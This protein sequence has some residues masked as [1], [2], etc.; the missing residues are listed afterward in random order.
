MPLFDDGSLGYLCLMTVSALLGLLFTSVLIGTITNAIEVKLEA[1]R[2]GNSLVIEKNHIV[3][4]GFY[5]GEYTLLMR[6][7]CRGYSSHG[8]GGV[9]R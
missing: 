9:Y 2:N 7:G 5:P 4:L 3:V 8:D 6:C 1:L